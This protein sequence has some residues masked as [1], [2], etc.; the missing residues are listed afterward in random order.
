MTYSRI[1]LQQISTHPDRPVQPQRKTIFLRSILSVLIV[2]LAILSLTGSLDSQGSEYTQRGFTR[3]LITFGIAKALNGVI[4]VA[5]G[6][7]VAVQPAGIGINFT[8]GQILDPVNDL[9]EQ[10]SW[11]ML[12]S[13]V[14]LGVQRTLIH[15]GQ[16]QALNIFV[17]IMASI[18]LWILWYGQRSPGWLSHTL[19][20]FSLVLLILRFSVPLFSI[21]N[22]WVYQQFLDQEYNQASDQLQQTT[23]AITLLNEN[24]QQQVPDVGKKSV[25]E[26]ARDFYRSTTNM[27]DIE[28]RINQYREAAANTTENAIRIIVVFIIQI[29]LMPLMFIAL[30][31]YSIKWLLRH[32]EKIII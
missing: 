8:P 4:S 15:I 26:T 9:I 13:T 6:T 31:I 29:V 16:W 32:G 18:S 28:K 1:I 30:V 21:G 17:C 19:F 12:A 2:T 7:E 22:E 5:Q 3:A 23:S 14:S 20:K 11:V 25:W 10:F 24:T 27:L